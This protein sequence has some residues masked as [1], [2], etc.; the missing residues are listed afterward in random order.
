MAQNIGN[1]N[2]ENRTALVSCLFLSSLLFLRAYAEPLRTLS[3]SF[4]NGRKL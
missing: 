2:D 4:A 1:Q 3:E